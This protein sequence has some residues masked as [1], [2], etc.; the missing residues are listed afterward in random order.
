MAVYRTVQALTSDEIQELKYSLLCFNESDFMERGYSEDDKIVKT[1]LSAKETLSAD[2]IS[3][4]I[5]YKI[6]EGISF[7][8]YDFFCNL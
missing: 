2:A 8:K 5:V 4:E 3:N 7:V 1:I 6:Y